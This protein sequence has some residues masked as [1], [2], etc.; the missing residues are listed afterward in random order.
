MRLLN[1]QPRWF[2]RRLCFC[3]Y[4]RRLSIEDHIK[5]Y[6]ESSVLIRRLTVNQRER[7]PGISFSSKSAELVH[8]LIGGGLVRQPRAAEGPADER[9]HHRL[10]QGRVPL[11]PNRKCEKLWTL[12]AL[13]RSSAALFTCC[14]YRKFAP[15]S[16]PSC[17][18]VVKGQPH[19]K[20]E[21][22]KGGGKRYLGL[23]TER[24]GGQWARRLTEKQARAINRLHRASRLTLL[25]WRLAGRQTG[26]YS[27]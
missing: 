11:S 8:T 9:C 2:S 6:A 10:S 23:E 13:A 15:R 12:P 5:E 4:F 27:E 3:P 21:S 1:A 17:I 25:S 24:H 18:P 20:P 19:R 22:P 7:R 26:P 16:M 14:S